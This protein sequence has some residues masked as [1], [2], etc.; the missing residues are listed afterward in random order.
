V[1]A[2]LTVLVVVEV[3]VRAMGTSLSIELATIAKYPEVAESLREY[4]GVRVLVIGNSTTNQGVNLDVLRAEL[5][6]LSPVPVRV[7][8]MAPNASGITEWRRIL[9]QYAL[10][11]S[12]IA[13]LVLINFHVASRSKGVRDED[14]IHMERL[15]AYCDLQSIGDVLSTD[16]GTFGERGQFLHA[17]VHQ[18]FGQR[19]RIHRIVLTKLIHKYQLGQTRLRDL[20][21]GSTLSDEKEI[22]TYRQ[23]TRLLDET[24]DKDL[25]LAI[26][27]MPFEDEC[28]MDPG[29]VTLL[30]RRDV[31]LLDFRRVEDVAGEQFWADR[32]H[33]NDLGAEA[34]SKVYAA[35]LIE[36]FPQLFS[37]PAAVE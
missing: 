30:G 21:G 18:S 28:E 9:L 34:F 10:E 27:G 31:P 8:K 32:S 24:A 13:D 3:G 20:S 29:L 36:R 5:N 12:P 15:V 16:L 37:A 2:V 4:E 22:P 25:L 6:H 19:T 33:L 23:L 11:P 14:L 35:E 17:Y 1:L 26:V 7:E